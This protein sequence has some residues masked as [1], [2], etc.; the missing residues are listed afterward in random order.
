MRFWGP[1]RYCGIR[2]CPDLLNLAMKGHLQ[3]RGKRKWLIEPLHL[4]F[5]AGSMLEPD[6]RSIDY[7]EL[8]LGESLI[9]IR[10]RHLRQFTGVLQST[11]MTDEGKCYLMTSLFLEGIKGDSREISGLPL[12]TR[13]RLTPQFVQNYLAKKKKMRHSLAY[14]PYDLYFDGLT[15][16]RIVGSLT[17]ECCD[18]EESTKA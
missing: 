13:R 9:F 6:Y 2:L 5:N 11:G 15:E 3:K 18:S 12:S 8:K 4:R 14:K 7:K 1:R 10:D 16:I 17:E